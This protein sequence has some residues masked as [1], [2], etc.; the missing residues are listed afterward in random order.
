M[1]NVAATASR[2]RDAAE[3]IVVGRSLQSSCRWP[4]RLV[5]AAH[6]M[7]AVAARVV[8]QCGGHTHAISRKLGLMPA[9]PIYRY[10][11]DL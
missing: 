8:Y 11:C 3:N 9:A 1:L 4:L 2:G 6:A 10:S 7:A 5:V